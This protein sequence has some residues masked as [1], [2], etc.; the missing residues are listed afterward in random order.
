VTVSSSF[1]GSVLAFGVVFAVMFSGVTLWRRRVP[2]LASG[3]SMRA[4]IY[5]TRYAVALEYYGLRRTE[6]TSHVEALR[7]D[8]GAV[9]ASDI[10]A[11][12]RRLGP[13]RTL[14]AEVTSETLR[15]SFLRGWMWFGVAVLLVLAV[16][17]VATESFLGG[18]EA[19]AE[20]GD[21]A[22]WSSL[23]FD[24]EATMGS[25]GQASTIGFGGAGLVLFPILAFIFGA[26]LWRLRSRPKN[27]SWK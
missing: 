8:L 10:D 27:G 4:A 16:S 20:Q 5:L 14:A 25:D 19:V 18:F 24:V 2:G 11:T 7:G 17:I 3:Q 15:P 22:S 23:G 13:P 6:I 26:R 12:L 9:D 1:I 21:Q